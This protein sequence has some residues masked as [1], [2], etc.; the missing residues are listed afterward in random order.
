METYP[1]NE[2]YIGGLRD[3]DPEIE[4]HFVA[5]FKMPLWLKARRQLRATDRAEDAVQETLLRAFRY[6]QSGKG[7]EF[8]E[9][10]PA[11]VQSICHNVTLEMIRANDR[12]RQAPENSP[13]PEDPRI[14][15]H[16]QIVTEERQRLVHEVLAQLPD[17][18]RELLQ[19]AA[20]EEK[21][22]EELCARYGVSQEYLRVLLFRARQ[23]FLTE[24]RKR[25]GGTPLKARGAG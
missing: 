22:K 19:L 24:I 15:L 14:D 5:Y 21:D 18:D 23:R 25:G 9:R 16:L 4:S 6:F 10:L 3:R 17:K 7:L 11:F 13:D 20:I 2:R 8:P 1:F 12:Y